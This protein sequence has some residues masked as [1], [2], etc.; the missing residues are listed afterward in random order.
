MSARQGVSKVQ[1]EFK[2]HV[3]RV[4]LRA[5]LAAELKS[6]QAPKAGVRFGSLADI[7]IR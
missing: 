6:T 1:L 2:L 4:L 3:T 7:G 5:T